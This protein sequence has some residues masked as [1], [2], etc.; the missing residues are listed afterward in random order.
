[1]EK[2]ARTVHTIDLLFFMPEFT[3]LFCKYI[4]LEFS[5][6]LCRKNLRVYA[7][8]NSGCCGIPKVKRVSGVKYLVTI[9]PFVWWLLSNHEKHTINS[10]QLD[11][12]TRTNENVWVRTSFGFYQY[13]QNCSVISAILVAPRRSLIGFSYSRLRRFILFLWSLQNNCNKTP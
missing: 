6:T 8:G 3:L 11:C 2:G 9:Y 5:V 1:M 7:A 12:L 4:H 13:T 10:G